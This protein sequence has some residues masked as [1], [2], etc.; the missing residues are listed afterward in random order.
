MEAR[1]V[2]TARDATD[3]LPLVVC[4]VLVRSR[5]LGRRGA[6]LGAVARLTP[7]HRA[8]SGGR[9][10]RWESDSFRLNATLNYDITKIRKQGVLY[11]LAIRYKAPE[12]MVWSPSGDCRIVRH[13]EAEVSGSQA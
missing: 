11:L 7:V 2:V 5:S 3:R 10:P 12:M 13:E 8:C 1:C 9:D 4:P 6:A